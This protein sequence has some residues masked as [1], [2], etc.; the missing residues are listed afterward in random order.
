M[1]PTFCWEMKKVFRTA[2]VIANQTF[3]VVLF[4][5]P[6]QHLDSLLHFAD[7]LLKYFFRLVLVGQLPGKQFCFLSD[8][9]F[10]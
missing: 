10:F 1:Q 3:V 7:L 8:F 5:P 6:F 2:Q 9:A 4:L